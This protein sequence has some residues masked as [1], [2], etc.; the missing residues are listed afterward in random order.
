MKVPILVA[1]CDSLQAIV[2]HASNVV[3]VQRSDVL[4]DLFV[5]VFLHELKDEVQIVLLSDNFF[6]LDDIVVVKLT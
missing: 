3:L 1:R 5:H 6:E 4:R 2:S